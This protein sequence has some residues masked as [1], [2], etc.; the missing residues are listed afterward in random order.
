MNTPTITLTAA[1]ATALRDAL[2]DAGDVVRIEISPALEHDLSVGPPEHD[3]LRLEI[4]GVRFAIAASSVVRA[5]GLTIDFLTTASGAGFKIDNPNP[6][7]RVQ[8][9][10]TL[11][12]SKW[13]EEKREFHMLDVRTSEE[14]AIASIAGSI[15]FDASEEGRMRTLPRDTTLVFQ[16]HHGVRSRAAADYFVGLGFVNVF[17]LEG[18]I[19]AW[20]RDIDPSVARY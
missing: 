4:D 1:A 14:R 2:A 7:I 17:N 12:L 13:L 16:C 6:V 3:D 19:D 9:L 10:T 20:S 11:A 18:G 15:L 5:N 8:P